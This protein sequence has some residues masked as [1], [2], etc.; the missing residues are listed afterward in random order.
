MTQRSGAFGVLLKIAEDEH[1][2]WRAVQLAGQGIALY[3]FA[4]R[5]M[6]SGK[7][8]LSGQELAHKLIAEEELLEDLESDWRSYEDGDLS[9]DDLVARLEAFVSGFREH[10]PEEANS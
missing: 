10:Y 5:A 1:T 2:S 4:N 8:T 3:A 9:S 6:A 7:T